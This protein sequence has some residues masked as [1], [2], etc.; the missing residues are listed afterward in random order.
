MKY[1]KQMYILDHYYNIN[2]EKQCLAIEINKTVDEVIEITS[3][4]SFI[5]EDMTDPSVYLEEEW[6][7]ECLETF[8][9]AENVKDGIEFDILKELKLPIENIYESAIMG[10][11][12][13]VKKG[14][15]IDLYSARES[16]CGE[17]YF[18][19]MDKW[20]PK[21]RELEE[22][23]SLLLTRYHEKKILQTEVE[24]KL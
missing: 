2:H 12:I 8:Y 13:V 15:V 4:L 24:R 11:H 16:C 3:A 20:L 5:L 14:Y 6:L 17:K 7:I 23:K 19:I 22:L 10:H 9:G 18:Y 1:E 21:G